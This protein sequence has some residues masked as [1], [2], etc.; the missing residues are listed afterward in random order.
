MPTRTN[1]RSLVM[2]A[3]VV[4]LAA[5]LTFGASPSRAE[6]RFGDSTWVAPVPEPSGAP[7][8]PGPRVAEPDHERTWET[9]LRT[10][11]RVAFFP[12]RLM[13]WGLEGAADLAEKHL[14]VDELNAP[15]QPPHG[16]H[17]APQASISSNEGLG[18]GLSLKSALGGPHN[19]ARSDLIWSTKDTRRARATFLFGE[20]RPLGA[21]LFGMYRHRPNRRF[22]GIGN[23]A[24]TTRTIFL[25]REDEFAGS[26]LVTQKP[27]L[28]A[29]AFVG[30]SD[31]D[32]GPGYNDSPR[33]IEVFTPAEVPYLTRG[34][35]VWY[36]GAGAG[37][38]SLNEPYDP[39]RGVQIF[40]E[41]RH[42][43][44]AD[45]NDL[46]Y[47][48]YRIEGRGYLPVFADRR[49]LAGR[50]VL[51][52]VNP[53]SGSGPIPF[54]RL[55]YSNGDDRF[56]G[57]SGD[58]FRDKR[59]VIVQAEYRW[60]IWSKLW[61]FALAQ[62][63]AVAPS[64]GALR[65][66]SMHEAYGGGFRYRITD[67]QTARLELAKGNQGFDIDLNLEAPF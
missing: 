2:P 31:I 54:Y 8:D 42:V 5:I 35:R 6:D 17:A 19:V 46:T 9:V 53:A 26:V 38:A 28:H 59:L 41:A 34:S 14:P 61:A 22:Y 55:P 33:S 44:D 18:L 45:A 25:E 1:Q 52:G 58:R 12:F 30:L 23:D 67:T 4:I 32:I 39:A 24:G 62:R 49:I 63:A 15:H 43:M 11:F 57:Y 47:E 60:L 20:N 21:S 56:S 40:G 27:R 50:A 29:R 13:G 16:F 7:E 10:P 51:D 3:F 66:A 65:W 48:A 37:W 36:A 64:T